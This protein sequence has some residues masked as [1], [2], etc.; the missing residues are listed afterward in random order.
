MSV[1]IPCGR[2]HWGAQDTEATSVHVEI[3]F[4]PFIDMTSSPGAML[5][6]EKYTRETLA[7][8]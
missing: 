3:T 5:D 1:S 2:V 8:G 6:V 7:S 4:S